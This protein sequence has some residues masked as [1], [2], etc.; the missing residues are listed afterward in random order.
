M[1]EQASFELQTWD[2]RQ[3]QPYSTGEDAEA[4]SKAHGDSQWINFDVWSRAFPGRPRAHRVVRTA[5]N[6]TLK[7]KKQRRA[8]A[9][10]RDLITIADQAQAYAEFLVRSGMP[11]REAHAVVGAL[12][13]AHLAGEGTLRDLVA[14]D[15]QLG[16]DAA[17]LVGPGVGVRMRTSR[18]AAGPEAL[19]EQLHSYRA[20]LESER[21]L[22]SL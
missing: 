10:V 12:V 1:M 9:S 7:P 11:F 17:A 19:P 5:L 22:L 13:R 6:R 4:M 15:P 2:G 8:R 3:Y 16:P 18:G 14:R 21:S 20:M